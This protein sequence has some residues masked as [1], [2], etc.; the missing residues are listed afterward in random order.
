MTL[1]SAVTLAYFSPTGTTRAV[2]EALAQP[3]ASIEVRHIDLTLPGAET[4]K[5]PELESNLVL[6]GVPVYAGRVPETA[7]R[8]LRRLSGHGAPAVLVV[9]YGN[10]A[11][12]D[13]LV[14][15][16]DIARERGFVPIAGAAF[17]GEHSYSTP[18]TPIAAGR[19]DVADLARARVL[20]QTVRDRLAEVADLA[21]MQPLQLPG[22][23][24][25]RQGMSPSEVAPE[26]DRGLC[27]LCE[28]CAR[29]CPVA[30]ITVGDRVLTD[31]AACILC[32]A[33]VKACPTGARTMADPGV[34]HTAHW[35]ATEHGARKEAEIFISEVRG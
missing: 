8:R 33:C 3:L 17:I 7:V 29:V 14:E 23:R 15:L 32:C 20:G 35:L 5:L 26:T 10:R 13:A 22:N 25:Y 6:L 24:P 28:A 21:S 12:E 9:V 18:A 30:A 27:T 1:C 11:F 4:Q 16:S 31:G 2:L 34:R 19:P